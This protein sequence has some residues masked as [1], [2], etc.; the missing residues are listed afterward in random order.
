MYTT[1]EG[2]T[3]TEVTVMK[4]L[5]IYNTLIARLECEYDSYS[6]TE[7]ADSYADALLELI[8]RDYDIDLAEYADSYHGSSYYKKVHEIRIS[9]EWYNGHLYGV[10]NCKV[11]DDW[12]DTDT[13]ELKSYLIGQHADGLGES[14]EQREV[15]EFEES[16]TYYDDDGEIYEETLHWKV[17]IS[18]WQDKNFRIMTEEELKG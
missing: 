2:N 12:T 17:Y 3:K 8:E 9:A 13:E 1:R 5:K 11:D 14:L 4:T 16:D 10:A 7:S 6:Y 18:F 15:D